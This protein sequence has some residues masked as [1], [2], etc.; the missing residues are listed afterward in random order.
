M[1]NV[2]RISLF[3]EKKENWSSPS[4]ISCLRGWCSILRG[5]DS[6]FRTDEA[7]RPQLRPQFAPLNLFGFLKI[8]MDKHDV[9]SAVLPPSFISL[10]GVCVCVGGHCTGCPHFSLLSFF[11]LFLRLTHSCHSVLCHTGG[12]RHTHAHIF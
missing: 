12:G 7:D 8:L 4:F 3:P 9:Q 11:F 2:F 10:G 1:L 6:E 5:L